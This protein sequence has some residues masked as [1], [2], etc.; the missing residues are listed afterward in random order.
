MSEINDEETAE[1]FCSECNSKVEANDV[2]CKA[3]GANLLDTKE[4]TAEYYCSACNSKVGADDKECKMCGAILEEEVEEED[5]VFDEV[6]EYFCSE[7]EAKVSLED[8]VCKNCGAPLEEPEI[9]ENIVKLCEVGDDYT[10]ELAIQHLLSDDIQSYKSGGT[11][12]H[13]G[14]SSNVTINVLE[15]DFEKAAEI[16]K[17][18]NIIE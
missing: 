5:D 8:T 2:T 6:E 14:V 12:T 13:L 16:L 17:A 1:Y 4:E 9:E 11:L 18:M 10:A 7:C 3:C 15:K